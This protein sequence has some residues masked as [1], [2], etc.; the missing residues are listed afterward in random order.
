MKVRVTFVFEPD[1]PDDQD[2]TGLAEE[3]FLELTGGLS[4]E[5]GAEDIEVS[6]IKVYDHERP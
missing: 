2:P 6:A 4:S 1:E 5:Y 3:E